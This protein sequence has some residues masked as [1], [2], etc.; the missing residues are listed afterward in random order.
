MNFPE[1]PSAQGSCRGWK[2]SLRNQKQAPPESLCTAM[3]C[4]AKP[5]LNRGA[6]S[7]D[8]QRTRCFSAI[9]RAAHQATEERLKLPLMDTW[10]GY[11]H[12][13]SREPSHGGSPVRAAGWPGI[14]WGLWLIHPSANP[15]CAPKPLPP[16]VPPWPPYF[17]R[18]VLRLN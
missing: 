2:A 17:L 7:S 15:A 16:P 3:S 14:Q 9:G 10:L 13:H 18:M 12:L 11:I 5:N 1:P 4:R 6:Q 8:C